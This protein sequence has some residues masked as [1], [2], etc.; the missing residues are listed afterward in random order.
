ML[1]KHNLWV[2]PLESMLRP[3]LLSWHPLGVLTLSLDHSTLTLVKSKSIFNFLETSLMLY[4][5]VPLYVLMQQ[6]SQ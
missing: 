4:L 6:L 1:L 2:A 5:P 3:D